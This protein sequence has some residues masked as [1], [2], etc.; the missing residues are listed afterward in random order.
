[1]YNKTA[2]VTKTGPFGQSQGHDHGW[3]AMLADGTTVRV[4]LHARVRTLKIPTLEVG[5]VIRVN[6]LPGA[7]PRCS[8]Q[9]AD[10]VWVTRAKM[11]RLIASNA[12][13][14]SSPQD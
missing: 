5:Q 7:P 13:A 12:E 11:A 6:R 14:E 9:L 4:R 1:M 2:T 10:I 8:V 3:G